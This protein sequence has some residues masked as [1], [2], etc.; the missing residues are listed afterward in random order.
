MGPC[1]PSGRLTVSRSRQLC[2]LEP[3]LRGRAGALGPP[4][5][6]ADLFPAPSRARAPDGEGDAPRLHEATPAPGPDGQPGAGRPPVTVHVASTWLGVPSCVPHSHGSTFRIQMPDSV[7]RHQVEAAPAEVEHLR[8]LSGAARTPA[9]CA[10]PRR[11][12]RPHGPSRG[13]TATPRCQELGLLARGHVCGP[14]GWRGWSPV[15]PGPFAWPPRP[16]GWL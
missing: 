15:S 13:P 14:P 7:G 16:S 10:S 9:L 8:G 2:G 11:V 3:G 4:G 6:G 5:G 1:L 12:W